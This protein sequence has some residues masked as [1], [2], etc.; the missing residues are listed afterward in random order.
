[1]KSLLYF[2][3][4]LRLLLTGIIVLIINIPVFPQVTFWTEAFQ[5]GCASGCLAS[6]YTGPNGTWTVTTLWPNEGCGIAAY[7]N[8]WYVSGA[9]CGNAATVCGSVCGATDPSLHLGSTSA[10]DIGAAYDAGG[11]CP[12]LVEPGSQTDARCESP[13]I[14][15]TPAGANAITLGFNYIHFGD[16]VIDRCQLY[17]SINGGAAWIFWE[18]IPKATCCGGC[19]GQNQGRW[20]ARS[21]VLPGTC[22]NI[23]NFKIAFRWI[24]NDDGTGLDPSFAVDDIT[25]KYTAPLPITWLSFEGYKANSNILLNWKTASEIN[26]DYFEVQRSVDGLS[27]TAI[28]KVKGSGNSNEIRSYSFTDQNIYHGTSYYKIKQVDYDGASKFSGTISV[29]YDE[30]SDEIF[31]LQTNMINTT[32]T[33]IINSS[34]QNSC[35]MEIKDVLGKTINSQ[36]LNVSKGYNTFQYNISSYKSGVYFIILKDKSNQNVIANDKFIKL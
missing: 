7:P 1:M 21:Y 14:N 19:T 30:S 18:N 6:S 9:E 8:V 29:N 20:T 15:T 11:Y 17:Y 25:L 3:S 23:V 5:N 24:N 22:N 13:N 10:G 31:S 27:F 28:G 34:Y 36:P 32:L 16:G 2:K 4:Y 33:A 35:Y 26:N 12:L